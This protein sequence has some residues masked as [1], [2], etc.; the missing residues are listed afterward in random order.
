MSLRNAVY[1]VCSPRPRVGRTLLARLLID[2]HLANGRDVEAFDLN[3]DAELSRFFPEQVTVASVRDIKGQMALFD[4]LVAGEASRIVDVGNPVLPDFLD[5][6]AD[7]GF[8]EEARRREI[9]PV[10]LFVASAGNAP[11]DAYEQICARLPAATAVP[12]YNEGGGRIEPRE[13]F[14]TE[15]KSATPIQLPMLS[16]GLQRYIAKPPFSFS[17]PQTVALPLDVDFELQKWMRR[18]FVEFREME[19]RILL[20]DLQNSLRTPA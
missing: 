11:R 10:I 2:F 9:A 1:I 8:T 14:F 5:V 7:T 4:R 15:G 13:R 3:E 19:L 18:I 12:V 20:T 17:G 6:M 16:P